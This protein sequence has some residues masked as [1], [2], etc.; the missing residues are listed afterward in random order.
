[1]LSQNTSVS[2]HT[3]LGTTPSLPSKI[4]D[5]NKTIFKNRQKSIFIKIDPAA[6]SGRGFG[7]QTPLF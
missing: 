7:G 5:L 1:M 3:D 4:N 6:Y 2:R